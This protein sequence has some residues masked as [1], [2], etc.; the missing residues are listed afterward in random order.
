MSATDQQ[1][2]MTDVDVLAELERVL[3]L[4]L[5]RISYLKWGASDTPSLDDAQRAAQFTASARALVRAFEVGPI[6][7]GDGV[8]A[9]TTPDDDNWLVGAQGYAD[10]LSALAAKLAIEQAK[11][12]RDAS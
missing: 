5:D 3:G 8:H 6:D 11:S 4:T 9:I 12:G 7:V 10:E 1:A 2:T